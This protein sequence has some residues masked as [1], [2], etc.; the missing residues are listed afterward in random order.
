MALIDACQGGVSLSRE[1]IKFAIGEEV[2]GEKEAAAIHSDRRPEPVRL[3]GDRGA[4]FGQG[5]SVPDFLTKQ[6]EIRSAKWMIASIKRWEKKRELGARQLSFQFPDDTETSQQDETKVFL[7]SQHSRTKRPASG[8][9]Y[10]PAGGV[11]HPGDMGV[12][13]GRTASDAQLSMQATN[14]PPRRVA[15]RAE[16]AT[17]DPGVGG[18]G[19]D[20]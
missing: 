4:L 14:E 16:E 20:S 2:F 11:Q 18:T 5:A 17:G 10:R 7:A 3:A 15:D 1:A 9:I 13:F 19:Y 8:T 12:I 6:M